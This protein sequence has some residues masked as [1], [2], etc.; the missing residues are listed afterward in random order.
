MFNGEVIKFLPADEDR[1][2]RVY[3]VKGKE[4]IKNI[5]KDTDDSINDPLFSSDSDEYQ[6]SSSDKEYPV[7]KGL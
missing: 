7:T 4:K 5:L 3:K 6:P 1:P 2:S